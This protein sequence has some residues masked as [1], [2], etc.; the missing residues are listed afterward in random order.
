MIFD[1]IR[2]WQKDFTIFVITHNKDLKDKFSHAILVEEGE[3]GAEAR[4]VGAW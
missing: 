3:D 1:A 4:L 2:K